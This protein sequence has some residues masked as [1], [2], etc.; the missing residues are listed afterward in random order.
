MSR[1]SRR[2][3]DT[4]SPLDSHVIQSKAIVMLAYIGLNHMSVGNVFTTSALVVGLPFLSQEVK[5]M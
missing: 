3:Q 2:A 1:E 5:A 4:L